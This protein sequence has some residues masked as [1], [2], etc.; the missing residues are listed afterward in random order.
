MNR[1]EFA[2]AVCAAVQ[3]HDI[4]ELTI[5][6]DASSVKISVT[7][8]DE[9]G[10]TWTAEETFSTTGLLYTNLTPATLA[11][12]TVEGLEHRLKAAAE[13]GA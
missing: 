6:A 4:S 3:G 12:L 13:N 2:A 1:F 10:R 7:R 8:F 9:E 11:N 5:S